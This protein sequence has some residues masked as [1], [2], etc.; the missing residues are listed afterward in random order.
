M[1]LENQLYFQV[2]GQMEGEQNKTMDS[3][4]DAWFFRNKRYL[5]ERLEVSEGTKRVLEFL[6][7]QKEPGSWTGKNILEIGACYGYNLKYLS[8]RLGTTCYGI[9]PSAAAINYGKEKYNG[10]IHL[11]QGTSDDLP[12]ESEKFDVVIMGFCMYWVGRKYLMR[13]VAEADRVLKENG[14]LMLIDFDT[15]MPYKRV[16]VHNSEVWTYKMQYVNL[17]LANPQY[18]LVN[19]TNYS[20]I[21][22]AFSEDIQERISFNV[23]YK[24]KIEDAYVRN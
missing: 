14:Y 20:D 5:E 18:Y 4:A 3:E 1:K 16:N 23:L 12:Y 19:K 2:Y 13:T 24:E 15:A 8:D 17:F 9:E 10:V 11:E 6:E 21:S 7:G 22:M